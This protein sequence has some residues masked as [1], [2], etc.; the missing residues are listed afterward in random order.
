MT[1][2]WGPTPSEKSWVRR[3]WRAMNVPPR[4][5]CRSIDPLDCPTPAQRLP[6]AKSPTQGHHLDNGRKTQARDSCRCRQGRQVTAHQTP[7]MFFRLPRRLRLRNTATLLH[8]DFF[9]HPGT[10]TGGG[11]HSRRLTRRIKMPVDQHKSRSGCHL[12]MRLSI[13]AG[14]FNP[15]E[16][17]HVLAKQTA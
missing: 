6:A 5:S 13:H 14:L 9:T 4:R 8:P 17:P 16:P 1:G 7:A 12:Y 2:H 15:G 11:C 10:N 3:K